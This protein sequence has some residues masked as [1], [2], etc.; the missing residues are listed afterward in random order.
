MVLL[1]LYIGMA[2]GVS[3]LCSLL[4]ATLLSLTPTYLAKLESQ[5]P[6]LG[7]LWR[8]FKADIDKPLAAILSLNT[9]AHT[10]GAAGAGAQATKLFGELYFGIISAVLTLLILIF[11]E[12]IPK[13]IGAKYWANLARFTTIVLS[14]IIPLFK[15]TGVLWILQAFTKSIGA[16]KKELFFKREDIS[17]IAEIAAR[18]SSPGFCINPASPAFEYFPRNK[19]FIFFSCKV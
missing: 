10:I 1:A 11:S 7:I 19:N 3:F 17:T 18:R 4:E 8:N 14:S 12:I 6:K 9:I 16:S 2:L 15:Y 5:R 13:T